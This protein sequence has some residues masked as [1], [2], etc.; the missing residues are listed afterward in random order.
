MILNYNDNFTF[1]KERWSVSAT[2]YEK[3]LQYY[4]QHMDFRK[5]VQE[6]NLPEI[7]KLLEIGIPCPAG[8][9]FTQEQMQEF[10]N[11]LEDVENI[12]Y[13]NIRFLYK[14]MTR[15]TGLQELLDLMAPYNLFKDFDFTFIYFSKIK[16]LDKAKFYLDK[17]E[18]EKFERKENI[19]HGLFYTLTKGFLYHNRDD[20]F[21]EF[22]KIHQKLIKTG[23]INTHNYL[24]PLQKGYFI[25][26]N[27]ENDL[28]EKSW[29]KYFQQLFPMAIDQLKNLD[30]FKNTMP[31]D[32]PETINYLKKELFS[33]I[34][35]YFSPIF[36]IDEFKHDYKVSDDKIYE[37]LIQEYERHFGISESYLIDLDLAN[38]NLMD[39]QARKVYRKNTN[40]FSH[41][42]PFNGIVEETHINKIKEIITV[43]Q[44]KKG[45]RQC[46][47]ILKRF[48]VPSHLYEQL[49]CYVNLEEITQEK[50]S[51]SKKNKI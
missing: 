10:G 21:D 28:N 37:F 25:A 8:N 12:F 27:P 3:L 11:S 38:H 29:K 17:M 19:E 20:V 23:L 16:N 47:E 13:P 4:R 34:F 35:N 32:T 45:D 40:P 14:N 33:E 43:L 7:K 6:E 41:L 9:F 5:Y 24:A 26:E 18:K 46:I 30:F 2:L 42:N 51:N 22:F 31:L 49:N 48:N 1:D 15:Q 39:S 50:S 36:S 44:E